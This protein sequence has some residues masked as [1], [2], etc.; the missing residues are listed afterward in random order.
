MPPPCLLP[1]RPRRLSGPTA[2][3]LCGATWAADGSG[4]AGS[5]VFIWRLGTGP[6]SCRDVQGPVCI[7]GAAQTSQRGQDQWQ[8]RG[9]GCEM[10]AWGGGPRCPARAR[11]AAACVEAP[12]GGPPHACFPALPPPWPTGTLAHVSLGPGPP[13]CAPPAP[14]PGPPAGSCAPTPAVNTPPC[15]FSGVI[16]QHLQEGPSCL[17]R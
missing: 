1:R 10:R 14:Q 15:P 3:E 12:A 9:P 2:C 6:L 5:F 17:A 7:D 16:S 13:P 11:R 4:R 8:G